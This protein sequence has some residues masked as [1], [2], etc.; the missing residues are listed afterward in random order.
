MV[1]LGPITYNFVK[2]SDV[3]RENMVIKHPLPI[4]HYVK[5]REVTR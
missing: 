2:R 4:L 5:R 1:P 3:T